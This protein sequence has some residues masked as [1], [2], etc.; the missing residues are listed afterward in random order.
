MKTVQPQKALR[1]AAVVA[2]LIA[3]VWAGLSRGLFDGVTLS[4]AIA[5]LGLGALQLF[6]A[7]PRLVVDPRSGDRMVVRHDQP[8]RPFDKE[9]ILAR[10]VAEC[11]DEMPRQPKPEFPLV[12][13]LV[14]P[15]AGVE[16]SL[17]IEDALSG[18]GDDRLHEFLQQ[19]S[20]YSTKLRNWL[21][22]IDSARAD[23]VRVFEGRLRI[24]ELGQAPGDHV[25]L[26]LRF[27][28]GFDVDDELPLVPRLPHRPLFHGGTE[29]PV[30]A[31]GMFKESYLEPK[32]SIRLP[33]TD[34]PNYS[35]EEGLV[36]VAWDLGRINQSE[37]R[38]VPAFALKGP[39]PGTYR[40]G[41]EVTAEGLPKPA[42]GIISLRID[43]P[44]EGEP[45]TTLAGVE[46]ER[47]ARELAFRVSS[48]R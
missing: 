34:K 2:S 6:Q 26:K 18:V 25:R 30:A 9:A 37:R 47:R 17:R 38:D 22:A 33:G 42:K 3:L 20:D 19:I 45:I 11:H 36:V 35:I 4:I 31:G 5:A 15:L 44:E 1:V 14:T 43:R 28:D 10:Q 12:S 32:S 40:V 48:R 29:G 39:G 16:A 46:E 21:D 13:P 7:R 23:R 8:V 27:P 24:R 41:W